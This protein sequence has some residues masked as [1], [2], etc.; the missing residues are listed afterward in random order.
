[1]RTYRAD[2]HIHSVLSPCAD[3]EMSPRNI[4]ALA[5][6]KGLDIIA[7]TDHNS[8]LH[9]PVV[10]KLAEPHGIKVLFGSEVT[11]REEA[12]CLCLFETEVQRLAFQQ[13]I[14]INLPDVYN[15]PDRFGYQVEVNEEDEII[16]QVDKLLISALNAGINEVEATVHR[17]GGLFIP[18]HVDRPMFSLISQLGFI[19]PTL[20]FDALEIFRI[21]DPA[22][23][24]QKNKYLQ[25]PA[26][27]KNSDAHYPQQ[28]G[29]VFTNYLI[30]EPTLDEMAKAFKQEG[31]RKV[32]L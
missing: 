21:T 3:L 19:P 22:D 32:V 14:E 1:M 30:H 5:K 28:L 4:V 6:S 17:L 31:G 8:T 20:K 26:L 29:T 10:R 7:V 12:H 24:M 15:D 23:F 16:Q 2:L 9:G 18:A 27:I 13:F 25:N 11:T